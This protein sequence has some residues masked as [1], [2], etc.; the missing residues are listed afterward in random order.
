MID[1]LILHKGII[2]IEPKLLKELTQR[3]ILATVLPLILL[4]IPQLHGMI[5]YLPHLN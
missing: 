5:E 4:G 2:L 1:Y 3:Q